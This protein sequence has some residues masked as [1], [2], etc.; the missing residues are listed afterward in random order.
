MSRVVRSIAGIIAVTAALVASL[1]VA[2]VGGAGT[3]FYDDDPISREPE[4]Q[5]ASGAQ[6][7]DIDLAYDLMYNMFVT[8]RHSA[9]GPR[10][11]NVNSVDEVP[12]SSWFTNRILMRPL[13]IE[14]LLRGP[15]TIERPTTGRMTVIR[16]K[17]AGDAPGFVARNAQGDVGFVSFDPPSNPE[18]ATGA[19]MVASR[20][21]WAL[22]YWQVE[23]YLDR[24]RLQDLDIA[25]TA[26]IRAPSGRQRQM[27]MDDVRAVLQRSARSPDGSY[28]LV[29]G[30]L[31]PGR[32]LGGFK[33][34]GTRPDDPNDVVPH[35]HR[36]ELRAL[37][38]F[39]AWTNL[40]DLKA[41]NTIDTVITESGRS[42]VRHDLQDV[43]STFG[44][45]ANGPREWDEGWEYLY[46][47]GRMMKR[48]M[49][50]GLYV[51]PWQTVDYKE[52]P[53]IGRFEGDEFDPEAWRSRAPAAAVLFARDD[54]TFWAARRVMAFTDEMIR[55]VVKVAQF[56]DPAAER[57]LADVLIKRRD[58]IGRAYLPK[59]NPL[60]DFALD[61]SGVLTFENAAVQARVADAPKGG[62]RASWATFDNTTGETRP[63]GAQTRSSGLRM[64]APVALPAAPGSFVKIDVS[65]VDPPRESWTRPVLVY[66]RRTA[67]GWKLVGLERL[68][69]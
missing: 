1:Q 52:Y 54:D 46:E 56:T 13:S 58:K 26:T 49:S 41:G 36:R 8:P 5:N 11:Q 55:A 45:A 12:D 20:I 33:Y 57:H 38:V 44:I 53:A 21:F 37:K 30:R 68:P 4:T 51:R 31:L 66:F 40:V 24:S 23:Q 42:I 2:R 43:G 63:L 64:A 69:G 61:P 18:A 39:A 34:F 19:I 28:R 62:Y 16:A 17:A 15:N 29:T 27:T 14:E 22:G 59:I 3:K 60:V 50:F 10:A 7:W 6:A 65:A 9:P 48:L 47:G 32:V 35:E 67:E 25:D